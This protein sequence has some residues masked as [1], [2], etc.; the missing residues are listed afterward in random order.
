M[1]LQPWTSVMDAI[2]ISVSLASVAANSTL[3]SRYQHVEELAVSKYTSVI[4][5]NNPVISSRTAQLM[6]TSSTSL[7]SPQVSL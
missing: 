3:S 7:S 1:R 5:A 6:R 2:K 4:D